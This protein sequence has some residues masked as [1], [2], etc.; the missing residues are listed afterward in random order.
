MES[1]SSDSSKRR[2][3]K[4][5]RAA[6]EGRARNKAR[7]AGFWML[8]CLAL[9]VAFV[10]GFGVRSNGALMSSLG[11]P[12]SEADVS[13]SS[14]LA[15]KASKASTKTTYDSISA[16]ISEVEDM[17][18]AY[19]LDEI[20][21]SDG[22][23][24]LIA[25]LMEL[26]GDP[27]AQYFDEERY[28]SHIVGSSD[29]GSAGVGVLFADYNGRAYAVD[30]LE[31]SEAQA[32]GVM[33]GDFVV[34][35]NGDH[36]HDWSAA[37]VITTLA[38]QEGDSVVITWMRPISL[39]AVSGEE[40]TT[41][42]TLDEYANKN[43]EYRLDDQVGY[44]RLRQFTSNSADLVSAALSTLTERGAR[45]FVLDITDNSG[46]YLTQSL[47]VASLFV[48]SGVLVGI[49]AKDGTT[50]RNASGSTLT[51]EP[52]V[53]LVDGYTSGVA[54]VLAAALQDNQRATVVGQTTVGKGSVQVTRELSFGGAIR[55]TA[56]YYLTPLGQRINDVG[57][58]PN[59]EVSAD[60][61]ADDD[62]QPLAV[63]MEIARSKIAG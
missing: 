41:T 30:V 3:G 12:V 1:R 42:L 51:S 43:V 53:V 52:L 49:E 59:V 38:N 36:S 47:D 16:R 27:Y 28:R 63:A 10:A 4:K 48:P 55:Y 22:T 45:A 24:A 25:E 60:D 32:K 13:A 62:N 17:L 20:A 40:F 58:V 34:A 18:S 5:R 23:D 11:I 37:E 29:G 15:S 33:Q 46:G 14:S 50:T 6:F 31:S 21:L 57:V 35:I 7:H 19:S 39:D 8:A 54:E 26:T 61:A 2:A 9:V 56:A 44:I